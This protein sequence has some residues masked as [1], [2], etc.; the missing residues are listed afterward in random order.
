MKSSL[1]RRAWNGR[2][3]RAIVS[4]STV[5]SVSTGGKSCQWW[6]SHLGTGKSSGT[7]RAFID[8]R[9]LRMNDG[10]MEGESGSSHPSK[11]SWNVLI[12]RCHPDLAFRGKLVWS[13][14][15]WAGWAFGDSS[16]VGQN[17]D[18]MTDVWWEIKDGSYLL[19]PIKL[20]FWANTSKPAGLFTS[21][22][23][24]LLEFNHASWNNF[25]CVRQVLGGASDVFSFQQ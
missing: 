25:S 4:G 23:L 2:W 10:K 7:M 16:H 19:T 24:L 5:T 13:P 12:L 3:T 6:L 20:L 11:Q 17:Q 15:S 9:V 8:H 22:P 18:D 21:P 14:R 1:A